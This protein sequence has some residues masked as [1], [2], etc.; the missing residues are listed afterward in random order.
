MHSNAQSKLANA[1]ALSNTLAAATSA[2][3]S[4]IQDVDV[5]AVARMIGELIGDAMDAAAGV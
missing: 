2:D 1:L 5:H 4:G 3:G